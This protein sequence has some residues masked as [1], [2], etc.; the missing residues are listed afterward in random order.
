M[1]LYEFALQNLLW[2]NVPANHETV[3]DRH[4]DEV[5]LMVIDNDLGAQDRADRTY[6]VETCA[7]G[8]GAIPQAG[9]ASFTC[10]DIH[11]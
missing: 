6:C 1:T 4:Q 8:T 5:R 7:Q 10:E 2:A 9:T 3:C 11:F